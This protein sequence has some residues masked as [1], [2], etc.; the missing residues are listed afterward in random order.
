MDI[1]KVIE[2]NLEKIREKAYVRIPL[3]V[4]LL[5]LGIIGGF[6]PIIQGWIFIFLGLTV[7]FGERFTNWA[8]E[9]FDKTKKRFK[10]R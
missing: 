8:R 2:N 3:G 7:L 10:K 6:L 9:F 4:A 1:L 5:M